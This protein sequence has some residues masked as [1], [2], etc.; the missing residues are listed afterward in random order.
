M[1]HLPV[2][3]SQNLFT[4]KNLYYWRRFIERT[5]RPYKLEG[6]LTNPQPNEDDAHYFKWIN[7]E[8]VLFTWLLDSMKPEIS[9]QCIDHESIKDI[10][11]EV[12]KLYSKLEDESR[13]VDLNKKA[14]ELLQEH[15]SILEYSNELQ[16]LW[17]EIDFYQPLPTDSTGRE[18]VLKGRTYSFLTSLRPEF[19]TMRTLLFT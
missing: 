4:S 3:I 17:K 5:L 12:I 15:R 10:W 13:M 16:A 11:D 1:I 7:E 9:N 6:H 18:Y 19:E 14:M 8:D 2:T